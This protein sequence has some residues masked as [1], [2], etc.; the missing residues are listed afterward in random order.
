MAQNRDSVWNDSSTITGILVG[1]L[2]G[3]IYALFHIPNDGKTFRKNLTQFGA[4]TIENDID[5]SIG[6]AK[7]QAH[8][9]LK[10]TTYD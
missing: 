9:R 4:G 10:S 7:Q 2:L 3:A 6:D 1:L 5:V 8:R